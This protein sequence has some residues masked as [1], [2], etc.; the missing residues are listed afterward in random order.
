MARITLN[1]PQNK[2][3]TQENIEIVGIHKSNPALK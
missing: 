1:I 3:T 2:I